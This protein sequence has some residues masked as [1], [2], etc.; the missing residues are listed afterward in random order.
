[1]KNTKSGKSKEESNLLYID[2]EESERKQILIDLARGELRFD[3]EKQKTVSAKEQGQER[4]NNNSDDDNEEEKKK[5]E[6]KSMSKRKENEKNI[7]SKSK[8]K[9]KIKEDFKQKQIKNC[10]N[11]MQTNRQ[12]IYGENGESKIGRNW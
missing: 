1:L 12:N 11:E 7:S 8:K 5:K 2:K 9:E 4:K 6:R 3:V 10:N